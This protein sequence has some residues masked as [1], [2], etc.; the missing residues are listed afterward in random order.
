MQVKKKY[1]YKVLK[2][3]SLSSCCFT[4]LCPTVLLL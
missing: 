4:S 2:K 1:P 3:I